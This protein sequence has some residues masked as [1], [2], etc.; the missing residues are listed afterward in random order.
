MESP[1]L[2]PC[3]LDSL[4][5]YT[6][7]E[8]GFFPNRIALKGTQAVY[9]A[10]KT[11]QARIQEASDRDPGRYEGLLHEDMMHLIGNC[12]TTDEEIVDAAPGV[13]PRDRR[14][15]VIQVPP[16]GGWLLPRGDDIFEVS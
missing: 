13:G 1:P 16:D 4:L 15:R 2:R 11:L 6:L 5:S 7:R 9:E 12:Y 3:Q 10:S 8:G 14:G